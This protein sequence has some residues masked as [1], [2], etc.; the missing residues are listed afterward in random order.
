[1][2]NRARTFLSATVEKIPKNEK[3]RKIPQ[4]KEYLGAPKNPRAP[5]RTLKVRLI[6]N[7]SSSRA[8]LE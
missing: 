2:L 5:T 3:R 7:L 4:A 8:A 6:L 1:M